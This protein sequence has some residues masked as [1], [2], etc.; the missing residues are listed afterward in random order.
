MTDNAKNRS[1]E[2]YSCD[3]SNANISVQL[4]N[5]YTTYTLPWAFNYFGRNITKISASTNG[6]IELLEQGESCYESSLGYGCSFM[7]HSDGEY[8]GIMDVIFAPDDNLAADTTIDDYMA[9][10]NISNKIVIEW[11]GSTFEDYNSSEYPVNFQVV[12]YQNGIIQWNFKNMSWNNYSFD[13]FS[14]LYAK[15][16]NLEVTAGKAIRTQS[17]YYYTQ[18]LSSAVRMGMV[19]ENNV[20]NNKYGIYLNSSSLNILSD[21]NFYKIF[22]E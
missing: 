5:N 10:C 9:I 14:G 20:T 12:M 2:W 11:Y 22:D 8:K 4:D 19:T 7:I 21:M 3:M 18:N 17:S 15:E 1:Y 6:F 13:M 16:E